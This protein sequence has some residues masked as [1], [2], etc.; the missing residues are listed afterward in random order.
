MK[1]RFAVCL[2]ALLVIALTSAPAKAAGYLTKIGQ[3]KDEIPVLVV[4]GTAYEMGAAQG[5]LLKGEIQAFLKQF[6]SAVQT[7]EPERCS[8]ENLDAAWRAVAPFTDRRFKDELRGL[9][10][11]SG[12]PLVMLQRV[13][14]IPV[15]GDYS[16]S[17]VAAWGKATRN[18][19][20]YQTR[21]LDWE[22]RVGAQ[23]HPC[24]V[25]YLPQHGAACANITFTGFIGCNT[26][27][28][29]HGIIV[30][31]MGDSP[32]RDY[33]FDLHGEH[34][35]AML[36]HMLQ[37]ATQLDQAIEIMK[38]SHRIKKYHFVIG[39]GQEPRAVKILA[40]APNMIVWK[41]NDPSDELAPEVLKDVVYQDE[42]RGA[43]EPL[44]KMYGQLDHE[45]MIEICRRIPIKG[46]NL[47]DV[48]YDGT[49]CEAWIAYAE[50]MDEAYKRP[51]VHFRL[52]D[53]LDFSPP[54]KR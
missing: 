31:E 19:H 8:N 49:T 1:T 2:V 32:G 30:A 52:K 18:G 7:A 20:L 22:L 25:V 6:L 48:V 34:F 39:A 47:L 54:A 37:D 13:H 35:T 51:F 4:K 16:C 23:D 46:G 10:E 44:K 5:R 41:D 15:V 28:N 50:K 11:G 38:T 14:M 53:Y 21:N 29:E 26:G 27:M 17:S 36:R 3:G 40:H 45:K 12:L 24:I 33:P 43:F 9:A 42:G